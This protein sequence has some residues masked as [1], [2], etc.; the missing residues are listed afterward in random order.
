M[1]R[2]GG[3]KVK[4]RKCREW[5]SFHFLIFSPF[6][7]SLSISS[8]F[9]HSLSIFS[10]PGCQA[11]TS[12]STL[13]HRK[14]ILKVSEKG[15]SPQ[16]YVGRTRA[17]QIVAALQPGCEEM[18]REWGNEE[19]MEVEWGNKEKMRKWKEQIS[20]HFL[21]SSFPLHFLILS[22]FPLRFLFIPLFSLHFLAARL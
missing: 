16:P 4:M 10:K 14:K 20:L 3:N 22:P 2:E 13:L 15:F 21:I 7:P 9:S 6:P 11:A 19:E 17:A 12:C 5:V 1:D 18:K 8:S